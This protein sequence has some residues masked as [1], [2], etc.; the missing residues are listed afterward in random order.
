MGWKENLGSDQDE[1]HLET[2]RGS[3]SEKLEFSLLLQEPEG[4]WSVQKPRLHWSKTENGFL[5]SAILCVFHAPVIQVQENNSHDIQ[6]MGAGRGQQRNPEMSISFSKCKKVLSIMEEKNVYRGQPVF[7]ILRYS[8]H[9]LQYW[10][11]PGIFRD[12]GIPETERKVLM[13]HR[14]GRRGGMEKMKKLST[15]QVNT[16]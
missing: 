10:A 4:N 16:K 8:K 15:Y 6:D 5:S 14:K 3:T 9:H 2:M 11:E 1:V 13:I 7:T 12:C